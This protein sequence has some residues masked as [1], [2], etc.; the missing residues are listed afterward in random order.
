MS[1]TMEQTPSIATDARDVELVLA[2]MT[3]ASCANRIERKLNKVDGVR[4]QVN[5]ATEKARIV[6]DG[7]SVT[8][9]DLIAAVEAAGYTAAI[10][11]PPTS[12]E[13]SP[14]ETGPD[15]A[16]EVASLRRRML[17]SLALSVP[18]IAMA[19]VPA[20]QFTSWQWL[21]LTLAAPVVVWG[22]LAV[23]PRGVDQPAPRRRHDGHPHLDGHA[24]GPAAGRSTPSSSATR[25]LPG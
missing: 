5:F 10:P 21:S 25:G 18:V 1:S 4:A 22:A 8:D 13:S 6:V 7:S 17:V 15:E 24:C 11:V 14:D 3:C 23:P 12:R 2:G 9:A 19:M 20:L 16:P